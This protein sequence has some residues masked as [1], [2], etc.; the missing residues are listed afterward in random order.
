MIFFFSAD[1][2]TSRY[3]SKP[4]PYLIN[5]NGSRHSISQL[6]KDQKGQ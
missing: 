2:N 3:V 6:K 1:N 4:P 5:Q